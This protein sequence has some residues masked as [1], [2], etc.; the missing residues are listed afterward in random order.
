[1]RATSRGRAGRALI[2]VPWSALVG[3]AAG[4][5]PV[6]DGTRTKTKTKIGVGTRIRSRVSKAGQAS[7]QSPPSSFLNSF[8]VRTRSQ[9][10]LPNREAVA[11]FPEQ[12]CPR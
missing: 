10:Q 9:Q 6:S 4:T 2:D 1:M 11:L 8:V 3:Q 12:A 7:I 5:G